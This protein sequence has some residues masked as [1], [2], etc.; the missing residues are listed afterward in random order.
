ML[1]HIKLAPL[2][3]LAHQHERA[4]EAA[5]ILRFIYVLVH[6]HGFDER[7]D[8]ADEALG[9][10]LTVSQDGLLDATAEPM[11]DDII[12]VEDAVAHIQAGAC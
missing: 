10:L 8:L 1:V 4:E 12:V 5:C 9:G 2:E 6:D 7:D 3:S 11:K